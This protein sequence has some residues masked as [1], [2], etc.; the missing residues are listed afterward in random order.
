MRSQIANRKSKILIAGA[1]PAG[2]SLAIRLAQ[3]G[4]E[5]T[6]I[7]RER[8]PREKLC[9]E[10]IS[11]ECLKHFDELGVLDEMCNAGGD[12]IYETRFFASGGK[13]VVVPNDWFRSNS[14][15][16]SLS[17]SVMDNVL[18]ERARETGVGVIDGCAVTSIERENG[19]IGA[20]HARLQ[21]GNAIAFNADLYVDATGR[22]KALTRPARSQK[23]L[24]RPSLVGF[25]AHLRGTGLPR[26]LC[27]IYSFDGGYAG[28]SNVESDRA[29]LCF[30]VRSEVVRAAGSDAG[31]IVNKVIRQN[32]RAADTLSEWE[33]AGEWLAVSISNFGV[34]HP[35]PLDNLLTVG[36]AAAFIDPFTG[37]GMLMA[38]ESSSI[39][40]GLIVSGSSR[41]AIAG[42]YSAA[43][44][45]R[46]SKRLRVCSMLR[47]TAFMPRL[48]SAVVTVLGVSPGA[49]RYL[50]RMTRR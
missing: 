9:G 30:L 3:R 7:E 21:D 46:F 8:F 36:D 35:A 37:S 14:H 48:A 28:L 19:S 31:E 4:F 38:V 2:S 12:R 26:G 25:K 16:L 23:E 24:T 33:L 42:D 45:S 32:R 34:T 44:R 18:L 6:L 50:A 20:V 1:G 41:T 13:S 49:T 22:A 43:Y 11:P 39:L 47:R 40:A 5:T 10:F 27:E 17:R 15:A 29:N